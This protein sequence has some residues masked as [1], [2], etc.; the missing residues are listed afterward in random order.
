MKRL[1]I[2]FFIIISIF[3]SGFKYGILLNT[4]PFTRET[5]ATYTRIL[6]PNERIYWL[7]ISK[8]PMKKIQFIKVQVFQVNDRG[9]W[10]TVTGIVYTHD[11]RLNIDSPYFYTDYFVLQHTGHFYMEVFDKNKLLKPLAV[12]DFYVK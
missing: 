4:V 7:F 10:N 9:P 1:L 8:R 11:Y 2:L 6:K 5:A 3:T 12:I